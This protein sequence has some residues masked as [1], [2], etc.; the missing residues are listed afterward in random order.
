MHENMRSYIGLAALIIILSI[1]LALNPK[2]GTYDIEIKQGDAATYRTRFRQ[3]LIGEEAT[4]NVD[5]EY[6]TIIEVLDKQLN[7]ITFKETRVDPNGAIRFEQVISGDPTKPHNA[8]PL[9]RV[10]DLFIPC[11]LTRGDLLPQALVLCDEH[12]ENREY[13]WSQRVNET[14]RKVYGGA[15][16]AANHI[17]WEREVGGMLSQGSFTVFRSKND[18]YD[19]ETGVLLE[20][21]LNST[22][23][24]FDFYGRVTH[25][26]VEVHD[27]ELVDT[28]MWSGKAVDTWVVTLTVSSLFAA[29]IWVGWKILH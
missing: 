7:N 27:Y 18:Y 1:F 26:Y 10:N 6:V 21:H 16:R 29:V 9:F 22:K 2:P 20:S 25:L 5:V 28:N 3:V 4:S 8:H 14:V 17:V 24:Y 13:P 19:L 12:D 23:V 11:G 15:W